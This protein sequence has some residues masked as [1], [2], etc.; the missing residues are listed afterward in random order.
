MSAE[1]L[2]A[3]SATLAERLAAEFEAE[4]QRA[5]SA[6]GRFTIALPGGSV[7]AAFF[8]RLARVAFD[9]PAADFFWVDERGVAPSHSDS[10]YH[11]AWTLWLGP[12]GVPANRIHRMPADRDNLAAAAQSYEAELG[13]I[14][15]APPRLDFVLLG[16]GP[17]GHVASL[18][19]AHPLLREDSRAVSFLVD[20][21]KP[22]P[23][24]MT[25]T[26]PILCGA[27]R[28]VVA[29]LGESKAA[30][31]REA[32]EDADDSPLPVAAIARDATRPLF[33]MDA[34]AAS[35]IAGVSADAPDQL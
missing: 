22:P 7:A 11:A 15:G 19:R 28:V 30:V 24:R 3:D 26:M 35:L 5:L 25:L 17:D 33:L 14:A 8:P 10:N 13:R 2:I 29:A 32:L 18:F 1:V 23:R 27:G 34:G 31:L 4:G 9:W 20:A 16:T 12:V 21:P 6:R